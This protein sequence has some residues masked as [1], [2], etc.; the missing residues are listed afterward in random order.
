MFLNSKKHMGKTIFSP[1]YWGML[2]HKNSLEALAQD[3][4]GDRHH[5][6]ALSTAAYEKFFIFIRKIPQ[7]ATEYLPFINFLNHFSSTTPQ[8]YQLISWPKKIWSF[9]PFLCGSKPPFFASPSVERRDGN[10]PGRSSS[11]N[12]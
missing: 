1:F 9:L 6:S 7:S 12:T 8:L 4:D 3:S 10:G 11:P 5:L 2:G